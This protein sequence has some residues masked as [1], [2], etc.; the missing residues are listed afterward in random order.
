[1]ATR[2]KTTNHK[3][4]RH[5]KGDMEADYIYTTGIAGDKFF[6]EIKESAKI[7]GT[8]CKNCKIVYVPPRMYCEQCFEKLDEWLDVSD[9]GTVHT[10]TICNMD[11]DGSKMDKPVIMAVIK[12]DGIHG[13]II[14]RLGEVNPE[15]VK[16]GMKVQAIFKNREEREGSILDIKYFKP[17]K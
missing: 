5:W 2:E 17:V 9:K 7:K 3:A 13:G 4:L 6:K 16:I 14:H 1:M 15:D 10:Y 11:L 12:L 8:K